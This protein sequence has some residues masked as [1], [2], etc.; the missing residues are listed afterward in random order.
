[1]PDAPQSLARLPDLLHVTLSP[2]PFK[3]PRPKTSLY[4]YTTVAGLFGIINSASVWATHTEYMNDPAEQS[5][6]SIILGECIKALPRED[7]ESFPEFRILF[8]SL[9]Q[10]LASVVSGSVHVACFTEL[11]DSLVLWNTY[12][13]NATGIA[14]ESTRILLSEVRSNF[15]HL[16][17]TTPIARYRFF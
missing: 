17:A 3:F 1:M 6:P 11:A 13:S 16:F 2:Q 8:D 5:Y 7:A 15:L 9:L 12:T 10:R 14:L 4:H